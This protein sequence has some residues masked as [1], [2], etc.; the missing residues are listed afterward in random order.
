MIS[1]FSEGQ[2]NAQKLGKSL[3]LENCYCISYINERNR[4]RNIIESEKAIMEAREKEKE[5]GDDPFRRRKCAP[6]LVHKFKPNT[7]TSSTPGPHDSSSAL[8]SLIP[9]PGISPMKG[10]KTEKDSSFQSCS[11][12]QNELPSNDLFSAHNFDFGGT[13][14]LLSTLNLPSTYVRYKVLLTGVR[15]PA[16]EI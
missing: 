5:Q 2:R 14:S 12:K 11:S 13:I 6:M 3:L 8:D 1:T 4:M 7:P 15:F 9:K 10:I 16:R